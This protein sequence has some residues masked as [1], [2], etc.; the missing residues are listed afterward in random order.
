MERSHLGQLR[1]EWLGCSGSGELFA[2]YCVAAVALEPHERVAPLLR[3]ASGP[4]KAPTCGGP[5]VAVRR[6]LSR[7]A[8]DLKKANQDGH[9]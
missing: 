2:L 5:V 7:E 4:A 6:W 3:I 1:T 9:W 8:R